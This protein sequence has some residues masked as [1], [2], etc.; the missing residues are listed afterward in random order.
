MV[1]ITFPQLYPQSYV[2]IIISFWR[3]YIN[4]YVLS[5]LRSA[6]FYLA[7]HRNLEMS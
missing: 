6:D 5:R 3:K 2:T 7:A 1:E 4:A